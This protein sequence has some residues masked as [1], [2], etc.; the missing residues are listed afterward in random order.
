MSEWNTNL[1]PFP[2]YMYEYKE[3]SK[4]QAIMTIDFSYDLYCSAMEVGLPVSKEGTANCV[5]VWC[6]YYCGDKNEFEDIDDNWQTPYRNG[7]FVPY[8]KQLLQFRKEG[9]SVSEG[10]IVALQVEL[11]ECFHFTLS[12]KN[13]TYLFNKQD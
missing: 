1:Y 3:L 10:D 7:H 9:R 13:Y 2:L 5:V 4:P 6:E 12:F 11:D 8:K